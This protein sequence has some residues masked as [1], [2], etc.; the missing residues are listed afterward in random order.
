MVRQLLTH[1]HWALLSWIC[2]HP[3][4]AP[5][6]HP[7]HPLHHRR[8]ACHHLD[9]HHPAFHR[10]LLSWICRHPRQAPHLHHCHPLHHRRP[11]GHH[12]DGHHPAF[13]RTLHQYNSNG[14]TVDHWCI[15]ACCDY[16]WTPWW[17]HLLMCFCAC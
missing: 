8:P 15:C 4:Q 12:P 6:L 2:R 9:G 14:R 5:H 7:R 17:V 1:H 13:H 16:P 3:R 11:A 10:A